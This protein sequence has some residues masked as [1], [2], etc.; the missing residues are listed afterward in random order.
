MDDKKIGND[1]LA[2]WACIKLDRLQSGYRLVN[3]MDAKGMPS[4]GALLVKITKVWS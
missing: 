2:A 1:E 4:R 3:L